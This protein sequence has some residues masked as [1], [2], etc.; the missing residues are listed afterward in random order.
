VRHKLPSRRQMMAAVLSTREK[1]MAFSAAE[2]TAMWLTRGRSVGFGPEDV[3]AIRPQ[4][5]PQIRA[6]DSLA[7][8]PSEPMAI[9][10]SVP[11]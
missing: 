6:A 2:L 9:P 3:I 1:K 4:D 8:A 11:I 10:R 7:G 5:A